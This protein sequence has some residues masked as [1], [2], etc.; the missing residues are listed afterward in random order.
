MRRFT[1]WLLVIV[2]I[3]LFAGFFDYPDF[4]NKGADTINQKFDRLDA[5]ALSKP[6]IE[7]GYKA[8]RIDRVAIP[9]MPVKPYSLGLDLQGGAHLAYEADLSQ[10][11]ERERLEA[12]AGLRDVIE[13]RVNLFGVAEPVVQT[14]EVGG[15]HRLLVEL[16]GITDVN[17]AIR[18]IGETPYLEFKE[19]K[20]EI[21]GMTAETTFM[22]FVPTG[23]TGQYLE[24]SD[25]SF[26]PNSGKPV[27][28][29]QFNEEGAK[30][31]ETL[32]EK[33][34]GKPLA[35][36]L[37][38]LPMSWP[39]VQ[40]KISGGQAVI[41]GDFLV[42]EAR[43][44]VRNL[45]SGALPVPIK[46]VAQKNVEA[47]IGAQAL[48]QSVRAGAL[49]FLVVAIFMIAWYRLPGLL[50]V[51][52]LLMYTALT[53]ALFKLIPVTLTLAG[54]AGFVLSVGMAVDANILIFARMREEFRSGKSFAAA[55]REG[56]SRAWPSIRDSNITSLL[57]CVVLYFF[58]TSVVRGF[59]L[60]LAIGVIV[61]MFTAIYTSRL[62]LQLFVGTRVE[63]W[64]W[65][66]YR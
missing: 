9:H 64:G 39:I 26:D 35:I 42:P 7:K 56:G 10:I 31:F 1:V 5:W 8:L 27:I 57:T 25:L 38:G 24:R 65:L 46:L 55:V 66:W 34:V 16:A 23:L 62:L 44:I 21:A 63:R 32:T 48:D 30:L 3:S 36:F 43:Q 20:P 53:L 60:T 6:R 12:M 15:R 29:L 58:T 13:R 41:T 18:M 47:S 22:D 37:D 59:A 61:S 14:S 54:I 11:P 51:I 17:Q 45:N 33:N 4:W 19:L 49:A 50:A 52:A 28:N 2:I 40:G